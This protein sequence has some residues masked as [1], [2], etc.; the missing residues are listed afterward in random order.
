MLNSITCPHGFGEPGR[1]DTAAEK[2][3][4][5]RPL[6]RPARSLSSAGPRSID[7]LDPVGGYL[8]PPGGVWR[9]DDGGDQAEDDGQVAPVAFSR[10]ALTDGWLPGG[11]SS[12]VRRP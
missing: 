2:R 5:S 4:R 1:S 3:P 9:Q 7:C 11:R 6:A 8:E 10:S 12:G